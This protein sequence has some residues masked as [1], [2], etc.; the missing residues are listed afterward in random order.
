M[1]TIV[2]S[3]IAASL[4]V[5]NDYAGV[6]NVTD[7]SGGIIGRRYVGEPR[8]VALTIQGQTSRGPGNVSLYLVPR[9]I[10]FDTEFADLL[11]RQA[12]SSNFGLT[13]SQNG[14]TSANSDALQTIL[15]TRLLPDGI[16]A[17][18]GLFLLKTTGNTSFQWI[19]VDAYLPVLGLPDDAIRLAGYRPL[20]QGLTRNYTWG[21]DEAAP[22][23]TPWSI[24]DMI[25]NGIVAVTDQVLTFIESAI[26]FVAT[27]VDAIVQAIVQFGSWLS[28]G[29]SQAVQAVASAVQAAAEVLV[30]VLEALADAILAI[31]HAALDPLIN[32]V[33]A[34]YT[35]WA[36]EMAQLILSIRSLS[37]DDFV[38]GLIQLTFFSAFGLAI[39]AVI[40]AFSV[41]E[42][43]TNAMTLGLANLAGIVIGAVAGLIIGML[44]VAAINEWLGS[45]VIED[46]L[47]AGFDDVTGASFS[48]AQFL[49]AYELAQRPLKPIQ[50]VETALKDSILGLMILGV[51]AAI[52][53][54]IGETVFGLTLIVVADV[55]ALYVVLS[56]LKDMLKISG[57]GANFVMMWY[58]FLYPV[59]VAMNAIGIATAA[60][61]LESD[62]G[63]LNSALAKG[64]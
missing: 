29:V 10:Y 58:P 33:I 59:T 56:G 20:S 18:E 50:G 12:L 9:S 49:F 47:P 19:R 16:A 63:K 36:N 17:L 52:R 53:V 45:A 60:T 42:K 54:T 24:W 55:F 46:L 40:V 48:V 23:T 22:V 30:Q 51:S 34:A 37:V 15:S 38:R 61:D 21:I 25:W 35:A 27:I 43:I 2:P 1:T 6:Y 57:R 28:Q 31:I 62:A 4:I 13:F 14:T 32:L 39:F 41:A 5:P 3:R 8:F 64:G 11:E 44:V 26:V 7:A